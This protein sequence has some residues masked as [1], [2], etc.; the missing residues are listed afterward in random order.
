[1]S[2]RYGYQELD[3]T[4]MRLI[5]GKTYP[6]VIKNVRTLKSMDIKQLLQQGFTTVKV[7]NYLPAEQ[8]TVLPINI[9][10]GKK[11]RNHEV[12]LSRSAN[13]V[14]EQNGQVRYAIIN[15]FVYDV[16]QDKNGVVNA[17]IN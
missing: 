7:K 1:M 13:F 12:V 10:S 17:L 3:A 5:P 14:L 6:E 2:V 16:Q 4:G 9:V 8:F 11:S 15:G